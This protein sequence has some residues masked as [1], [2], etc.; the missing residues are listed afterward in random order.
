MKKYITVALVLVITLMAA[1]ITNANATDSQLNTVGHIDVD[2]IVNAIPEDTFGGIY[3]N[4]DGQIVVNIV[5]D[6]YPSDTF[7]KGGRAGTD[8]IYNSV[9]ISLS[10]LEEVHNILI[11]YMNQF[12][13]IQ[14]D[15]NE[16]TNKLDIVVSTYDDDLLTFLENHIDLEHINISVLPDGYEIVIGSNQEETVQDTR[17]PYTETRSVGSRIYPGARIRVGEGNAVCTVG[18]RLNSTQFYTCGH[19]LKDFGGASQNVYMQ[20]YA[21]VIPTWERIGSIGSYNL[22]SRG[23][24]AIVTLL[25]GQL[26]SSNTLVGECG[27]YS[28]ATPIVGTAVQMMGSYSGVTGGTILS[29]NVTISVEGVTLSNLA[30][31]SHPCVLGDSGAGIFSYNALTEPVSYCY[32]IQSCAIFTSSGAWVTSYFHQ[33]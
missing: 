7:A 12:S 32:G 29:T 20:N 33:F 14:L 15:A 27:T 25:Y 3:V 31:S 6:Q 16:V 8:I 28:Y 30:E 26:P 2:T 13:I 17:L 24:S 23:D 11:P 19:V 1:L 22:G 9:D 18:P 4:S 10:K 21:T 5:G